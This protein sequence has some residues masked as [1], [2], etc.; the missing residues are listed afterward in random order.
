MIAGL[1]FGHAVGDLEL[2]FRA[3]GVHAVTQND[4]A[5]SRPRRCLE[6]CRFL[7]FPQLSGGKTAVR[8]EGR[9]DLHQDFTDFRGI[10]ESKWDARRLGTRP[11]SPLLLRFSHHQ[12]RQGKPEVL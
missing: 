9:F 3:P 12:A 1:F 10:V 8:M 4:V 5:L 11:W 7:I 2:R 6:W